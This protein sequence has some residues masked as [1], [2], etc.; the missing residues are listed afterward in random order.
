MSGLEQI[1]YKPETTPNDGGRNIIDS[2]GTITSDTADQ[3][4]ESGNH[5]GSYG[6]LF[7]YSGGEKKYVVPVE[8]G[9]NLIQATLGLDKSATEADYES[10]I[11]AAQKRVLNAYASG[12][13]YKTFSL[14]KKKAPRQAGRA[15][16]ED[17][18]LLGGSGVGRK[19]GKTVVFVRVPAAAAVDGAT[20][21]DPDRV[22]TTFILRLPAPLSMA[23]ALFWAYHFPSKVANRPLVLNRNRERARKGKG[24]V[25]K[26]STK[27]FSVPDVT[28]TNSPDP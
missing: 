23:N 5:Y 11:K 13:E 24:Y 6:L 19:I 1:T 12:A 25:P 7:P 21:K 8:V 2:G 4:I 26:D 10:A 27:G 18:A 15:N 22:F 9:G 28:E 16:L 14:G 20:T 17:Y 3:I